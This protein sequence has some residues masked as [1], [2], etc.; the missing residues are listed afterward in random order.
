L[1]ERE[2]E[3]EETIGGGLFSLS[4]CQRERQK[5]RC[6]PNIFVGGFHVKSFLVLSTMKTSALITL[7]LTFAAKAAV[8]SQTRCSPC[9]CA[10]DEQNDSA[11]VKCECENDHAL[12]ED[13]V[14]CESAE[15]DAG[16]LVYSARTQLRAVDLDTGEARV[17]LDG[18]GGALAL[19]FLYDSQNES[20]VIFFADISEEVISKG[21]MKGNGSLTNVS[22]VISG[23]L[24]SVEGL[25]VDWTS[26]KLYWMSADFALL[27]VASIAAPHY[28]A[29][30]VSGG[31]ASPRGLALDPSADLIAWADWDEREP[32][33]EACDLSGGNRRILASLAKGAWPNG[34][35]LDLPAKRILWADARG[36]VIASSDYDGGNRRLEVKAESGEEKGHLRHP[37]SV[38]TFASKIYWWDEDFTLQW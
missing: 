16:T 9:S 2:K 8:G 32:R 21:E 18:L 20:F 6:S 36:D 19:D 28:R 7:I 38:A 26:G 27:E 14:R 13:G 25:A 33:L 31:M 15:G 35:A 34:V 1:G 22:P 30:V 3:R 10:Q 12:A 23:G 37:F 29:A 5:R 17:V 11:F 24:S 4:C